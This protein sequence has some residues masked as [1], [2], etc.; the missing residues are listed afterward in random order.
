MIP[1]KIASK[2]AWD[3]KG[4]EAWAI[5][6]ALSKGRSPSPTLATISTRLDICAPLRAV[7]ATLAEVAEGSIA[8]E[9]G[10]SVALAGLAGL[11][12]GQWGQRGQ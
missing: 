2:T 12:G 6:F 4:N 10:A 7:A 1:E 8:G 3:R 9:T 5:A 11:A